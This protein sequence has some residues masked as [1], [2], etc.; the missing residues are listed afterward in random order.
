MPIQPL[1]L[2]SIALNKV[3]S[4]Y[5]INE[6]EDAKILKEELPQDLIEKIEKKD[7]FLQK[8]DID[9]LPK[10][11][12]YPDLPSNY[13][14]AMIIQKI[15]DALVSYPSLL[16]NPVFLSSFFHQ[17]TSKGYIPTMQFL[18]DKGANVDCSK[19]NITKIKNAKLKITQDGAGCTS[20]TKTFYN[21]NGEIIHT[22]NTL[23]S[24]TVNRA[25]EEYISTKPLEIAIKRG[26]LKAVKVLLKNNA[27]HIIDSDGKSILMLA[28]ELGE[29]EIVRYLLNKIPM[30]VN[31]I[32]IAHNYHHYTALYYAIKEHHTEV[33]RLLLENGADC[34]INLELPPLHYCSPL[35]CAILFLKDKKIDIVKLVLFKTDIE[36]IHA[37]REPGVSALSMAEQF[38]FTEIV[39]LLRDAGATR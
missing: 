33:I 22:Y 27:K 12:D 8:I 30:N 23:T 16:E 13:L 25:F 37:E 15:E 38:G 20:I 10:Q 11:T 31:A 3:T 14:N 9:H 28:S 1:S 6:V 24:T 5:D 4:K 19:K 29:L 39:D 35:M 18:I 34:N 17:A 32:T 26:N 7:D 2:Q 36:T 21:N